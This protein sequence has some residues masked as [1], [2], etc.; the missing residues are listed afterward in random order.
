MA[1][2]KQIVRKW[3]DVG[4]QGP[5][6]AWEDMCAKDLVVRFPYGP[7]PVQRELRGYDVALAT[8]SAHWK[9]MAKFE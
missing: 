9:N 2:K 7:P 1:D 8:C 5:A 3:L 4:A 6:E